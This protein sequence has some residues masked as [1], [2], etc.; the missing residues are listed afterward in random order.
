MLK[1]K[2]EDLS[3]QIRSEV[4]RA[5]VGTTGA[6]GGM[7]LALTTEGDPPAVKVVVVPIQGAYDSTWGPCPADLRAENYHDPVAPG[8]V[9]KGDDGVGEYVWQAEKGYVESTSENRSTTS[10]ATTLAALAA[11]AE[12]YAKSS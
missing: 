9:I 7:H 11:A 3:S 10:K 2:L 4:G 12:A 8:S 1:F 6:F 5:P